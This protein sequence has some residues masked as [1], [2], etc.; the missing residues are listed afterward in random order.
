LSFSQGAEEAEKL[1]LFFGDP[2]F[3]IKLEIARIKFFRSRPRRREAA[4]VVLATPRG[5]FVLITALLEDI[6]T[7]TA[8]GPT[9]GGGGPKVEKKCACILPLKVGKNKTNPGRKLN[10]PHGK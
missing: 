4:L 1:V 9:R 5:I 8:L 2:N 3:D 6:S 7:K 10:G